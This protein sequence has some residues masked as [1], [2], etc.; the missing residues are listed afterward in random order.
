MASFEWYVKDMQS[1]NLIPVL[2]IDEFEGLTR[3]REFDV[4]FFTQLRAIN[5]LGLVMVTASLNPL[6][7]LVSEV[8]KTVPSL[9]YLCN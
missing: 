8:T 9:T 1:R 7:D 4:T 5:Q 3:S 2:C 6:I